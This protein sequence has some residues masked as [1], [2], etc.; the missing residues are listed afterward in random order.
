MDYAL[1]VTDRMSK[2]VHILPCMKSITGE[3]T[4]RLFYDGVFKY[5]GMP[6][7]IVSD[8]DSRFTSAFWQELMKIL[9]TDLLMSTAMHP[10]TDGLAERSHRTIKETLTNWT[11]ANPSNWSQHISSVEFAINNSKQGATG[12]T[13]FFLNHGLHPHTPASLLADSVLPASLS[14]HADDYLKKL[15][16]AWKCAH[17]CVLAAQET[18]KKRADR[19]RRPS[20]FK[21]GD[22]VL[23][24]YKVLKMP[25]VTARKLQHRYFGPYPVTQLCGENAVVV[26]LSAGRTRSFNVSNLK[27][28]KEDPDTFPGR[29]YSQ[30]GPVEVIGDEEYF[31]IDRFIKNR[32]VRSGRGY[33]EQF[34]VHW[35]NYPPEDVSW[36]PVQQLE[37]E[38]EKDS[39]TE[40]LKTL[41]TRKPR[42]ALKPKRKINNNSQQQQAA[43]RT[44]RQQQQQ[45]PTRVRTRA[46]R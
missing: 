45:E 40:L 10:Q 23:V 19:H 8:R 9:G 34:L 4:A 7:S 39:F 29:D 21:V 13:P 2:M 42:P 26:E 24:S 11:A 18:M 44:Q 25:D 20:P 30:P 33:K 6:K 1:S 14:P 28:W 41:Q 17:Q 46:Q 12:Q 35:E 38:M 5:H 15:K 32:W 16:T 3:G 22:K 27:P 36:L 43:P 37:S 31:T